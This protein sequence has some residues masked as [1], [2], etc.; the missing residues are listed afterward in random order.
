MRVGGRVPDI[1]F[2]I[3]NDSIQVIDRAKFKARGL[4]QAPNH[5]LTGTAAEGGTGHTEGVGLFRQIAVGRHQQEV[6]VG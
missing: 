3:M 1:D 4:L 2:D 5:R 6:G